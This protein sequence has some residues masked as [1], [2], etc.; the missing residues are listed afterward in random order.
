M[1]LT[2]PSTV[3]NILSQYGL[4]LDKTYGQHFLVDEN[5]RKKIIDASQL[6]KT[7]VVLE[8]G[9]GIGT[10]STEIAPKVK[11][12]WLIELEKH[13]IPILEQT[14]SEHEN[15]HIKQADALKISYTGL[16]PLPNKVVSN[17]PYNI[18]APLIM[19]LLSEC[20]SISQMV[21]MV[22]EEMANRLTAKQDT[23]DYGALTLK[24]SYLAQ[25]RTL[26]KV[27]EQVF[28]P[29]PRVKSAVIYI[30]RYPDKV[31]DENLFEVINNTFRHRRK[32]IK[33]ALLLAGFTATGVENALRKS[34]ISTAKRPENLNLQNFQELARNLYNH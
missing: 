23:A 10:L 11:K 7:D 34:G 16:K 32:T 8:V 5:I 6:E 25:I 18:A 1:K 33:R 24:T 9:P 28:L 26:F 21:V 12:L 15:I 27:S 29:K 17:L 2:S 30:Q 13:F 3:I 31:P 4:R 19:K 22:Q 20:P 14:L